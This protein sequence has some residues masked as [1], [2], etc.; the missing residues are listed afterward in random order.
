MKT[1]FFEKKKPW[2]KYKDFILGYYLKPYLSKVRHLGKPIVIID[3]FAGPGRFKDGED[4]SPFIICK[5]IEKWGGANIYGVFIERKKKYYNE[6]VENI[7]QYKEFAIPVKGEFG[8]YINNISQISSRNTTFLYVDPFGV[9]DLIYEEMDKIFE[10]I[11]NGNSVELLLNFDCDG[12][13]RWALKSMGRSIDL[14]AGDDDE[15]SEID[16]MGVNIDDLNKVANGNYWQDIIRSDLTFKQMVDAMID[17]YLEQF[18]QFNYV[19]CYP[20]K[21]KYSNMAKYYLIYAT[22]KSDGLLLMNDTMYKAREAFMKS[23]FVDG[24]LFD[25]R[26][27]EEAKDYNW[28]YEKIVEIIKKTPG[29]R[30]K[31]IKEDCILAGAFCK[32]NDSD[33]NKAIKKLLADGAINRSSGKIEECSFYAK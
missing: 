12:F 3:C 32:Y 33:L 29:I 15:I 25:T 19:C 17:K 7:G 31:V 26:P 24:K 16:E 20:V 11:A 18:K 8:D 1:D 30:R 5:E 9:K 10:K 2:S 21:D 6:L 27:A 23:E 4:G 28:L 22:R 14:I 13:V